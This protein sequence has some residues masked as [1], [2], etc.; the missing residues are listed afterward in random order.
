MH[1]RVG[2]SGKAGSG[3]STLAH[4]LLV[5]AAKQGIPSLQLGFADPL[6]ADVFQLWGLTKQ[7]AGFRQRCFSYGHLVK[8]RYPSIYI[9]RVL[10]ELK[11]FE[12]SAP[13][14]D[15]LVV[16]DDLRYQ[17]EF[18]ALRNSAFCLVRLS[19][20]EGIRHSRLQGLG[21]ETAIL[22]SDHASEC[23]LDSIQG[24]DILAKND[25]ATCLACFATEIFD[26]FYSSGS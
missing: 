10:R 9:D 19:S 4:H 25:V 26:R 1:L 8:E 24:W 15:T 23:E 16:V 12:C 18:T 13:C 11:E 21:V 3:K 20:P 5:R 14:P 6:K 7:D 17:G 22:S 2:I